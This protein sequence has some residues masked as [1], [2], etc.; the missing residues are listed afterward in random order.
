MLAACLAEKSLYQC[1]QHY[2]RLR[3]EFMACPVGR[4][5]TMPNYLSQ[6][7]ARKLLD[8]QAIAGAGLAL[9]T[10]WLPPS[11]EALLLLLSSAAVRLHCLL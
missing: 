7:Y 4:P 3:I 2:S 10:Y 8:C 11:A 5:A 9:A 1:Q 6:V